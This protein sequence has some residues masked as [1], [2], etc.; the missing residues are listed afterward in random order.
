MILFI[1]SL[2]IIL[3]LQCFLPITDNSIIAL[4]VF[5]SYPCLDSAGNFRREI[6]NL[7][8]MGLQNL[9]LERM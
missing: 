2:Y 1:S 8:F 3:R 4:L 9:N 6:K 5:N 7:K